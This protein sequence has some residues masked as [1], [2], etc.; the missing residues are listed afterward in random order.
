MLG[1]IYMSGVCD[2]INGDVCIEYFQGLQG[3]VNNLVQDLILIGFIV[4]GVGLD[5]ILVDEIVSM[6]LEYLQYFFMGVFIKV[7]F[8]FKI[9]IDVK[10]IDIV[11]WNEW[12]IQFELL[13]LIFGVLG[14]IVESLDQ[15]MIGGVI[16]V[17]GLLLFCGYESVWIWVIGL[18]Y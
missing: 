4:C 8:C 10:W 2:K 1:M 12:D 14:F 6:V 18:E 5:Q 9:N 7:I 15:G 11:V 3:F 13:V 17:D 16:G